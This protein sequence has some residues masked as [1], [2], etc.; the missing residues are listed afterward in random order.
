MK[1]YPLYIGG[2]DVA[3]ESWNYTV[4]AASFLD[5]P[6]AAFNLKRGLELGSREPSEDD[7]E[8]VGRCAVSTSEQNEQAVRAAYD[9]RAEWGRTPLSV[10]RRFGEMFYEAVLARRE[11]LVGLLVAEGHPVRLAEWEVSGIVQGTSPDALEYMFGQMRHEYD[12]GSRKVII[13]RKPDGV[14][15][16]SP[17]ANASGSNAALGVS[18]LAGGNTLVVKAPRTSP[19][20]VMFLY[21]EIVAPLL[22]ELGAP[23]GTLNLVCTGSRK[24][25]K[26]WI[27]SDLVNDVMF[28]GDSDTGS[29]IGQE[30]YRSG[31]KP[32]LELAG[33][34]GC[35]IWRDANVEMAAQALSE[36]FYGSGQIC[37]VPKYALVHPAVEEEL[38]AALSEIVSDIRPG[39]PGDPSVLLSPVLKADRFLDF[40]AEAQTAG[41]ELLAGGRRVGVDGAPSASGLFFEPTV[42]RVRGL[43]AA[44]SLRCVQ[45]ETFFPM[46]PLVV[47]EP[48]D[49]DVLLTR[50]IDFLN[51]NAYGLRN[52]WWAEDEKV[53]E[54]VRDSVVNGGLL[55]INDSHLGFAPVLATH[56]GTGLT[57]GPGGELNYPILRTTHLQGISIGSGIVPFDELGRGRD[58][59]EVET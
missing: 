55:K 52:S 49:D 48:A 35:V 32:V 21:R 25:L 4:D 38:V 23:P 20:A 53:V 36:C 12:H 8:I 9:A 46:L 2:R 59:V 1:S 3:G 47:P 16:L 44:R 45:H 13:E 42:L 58:Q 30:C 15:C 50:F 54:R 34:D 39:Y 43:E 24:V 41:A 51:S 6:R 37:M 22:D 14:V 17:P 11:E 28:F 7:K 5:D 18:A 31:K 19:L 56:G 57:G 40:L 27:E 10:R 26:Q 33:N 29:R